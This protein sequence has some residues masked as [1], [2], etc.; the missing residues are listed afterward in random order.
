MSKDRINSKEYDALKLFQLHTGPNFN[1]QQFP[2]ASQDNLDL[3]T[4]FA[5]ARKPLSFDSSNFK[6]FLNNAGAVKI[7]APRLGDNPILTTH[8]SNQI[9]NDPNKNLGHSERRVMMD[10]LSQ[11]IPAGEVRRPIDDFSSPDPQEREM[12]IF[13]NL[14][15][16]AS[17]Y[18]IE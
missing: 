5:N 10:G 4:E 1:R 12:E 6:N 14:F 13:K 7:T 15:D 3:M 17:T 2:L 11:F 16:K 9:R 18:R 8:L